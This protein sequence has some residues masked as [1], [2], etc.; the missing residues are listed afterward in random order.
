MARR[1]GTLFSTAALGAIALTMVGVP[2]AQATE[3]YFQHG[4]S[5][6][7]KAMGGAGI[8]DT[9]DAF[10]AAMNPAGAIDAG[11]MLQVNL[12]AF[13]P[14][15]HFTG[16][17]P[18][19]FVP[20]GDYKSGSNLFPVPGFAYSRQFSDKVG[21]AL[22]A[23]GNGGM[24]TS[25][26]PDL[27]NP[28]CASGPFPAPTGV[29]CGAGTGVNLNQLLIAASFAYKVNDMLTLGVSPVLAVNQFE[30]RG[31]AAFGGVS[32]NPLALT[33]NESEFSTGLGAR[34]GFQLTPMAGFRIAG[35]YQS[36]LNMSRFKKYEGLFADRGDFNIPENYTL[37]VAFDATPDFT[38]AIDYKRINYQSVGSIGNSSRI[39]NLFGNPGAAGFGWQNIDVIKFGAEWRQSDQWTW[40][41]GVAFNENPIGPDDV[42]LNILAPGIMK[43]HLTTGFE[44]N[45][46]QKHS[47]EFAFMYAPTNKVSGIEVTPFGPNPNRTIELRMRQWEATIGWKMKFG[48]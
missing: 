24:N 12:S 8:A 37:G 36:E 39:P 16:S 4:T 20:A 26:K 45:P 3:G 14:V 23:V 44:Y 40:R 22:T 25:W 1:T 32:S 10:G 5:A 46:S 41:A 15:R 47:F 42:T 7:S 2:A 30:A 29:F 48:K 21:F 34:F 11:N 38:V 27:P 9:R 43:T 35:T 13:S 17:G 31:L 19:G 6:R 28:V 18:G 33:N